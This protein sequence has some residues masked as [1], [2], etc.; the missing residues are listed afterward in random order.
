MFIQPLECPLKE[1]TSAGPVTIDRRLA[2]ADDESHEVVR[3]KT[4]LRRKVDAF[5]VTGGGL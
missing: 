3:S 4:R 5:I 1:P 2:C